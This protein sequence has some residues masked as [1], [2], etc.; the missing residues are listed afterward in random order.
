MASSF[1]RLLAF[2][3]VLLA[4]G[5]GLAGW[6]GLSTLSRAAQD[7]TEGAIRLTLDDIAR[8][9][10]AQDAL[11]IRPGQQPELARLIEAEAR[12]SGDLWQIRL[13]DRTGALL[14]ESPPQGDAPGRLQIVT[15][16]VSDDLGNPLA[17]LNALYDGTAQQKQT[18]SLS[19]SLIGPGILLWLGLTGITALV[20]RAVTGIGG[21]GRPPASLPPA[22]LRPAH[23]RLR[24]A[25]LLATLLMVSSLALS[26]LLFLRGSELLAPGQMQKADRLALSLA[27][28]VERAL[29]LGIPAAA[30]R[31][32]PEL[33]EETR[34]DNPDLAQIRLELQGLAPSTAGHRPADATE[35]SRP[36]RNPGAGGGEDPGQIVVTPD[37]AF[38][39]RNMIGIAVDL[40]IITLVITLI[41]LE[42]IGAVPGILPNGQPGAMSA[43]G[44][45]Q[46][47]T[48]AIRAPLFLFMF[49]QELSRPFLPARAIE[50]SGDTGWLS[51][52][53]AASLPLSAFMA[54]VALLQLPL[55]T[56]SALWGRGI[57]FR[58]GALTGAAG[59]FLSALA[60]GP[61]GLI[62]AQIT[63]AIGFALVFVSCQGHILDTSAGPGRVA[64]LATM[65]GAIMVAGLC[66]PAVGG[67]VASAFGAEVAFL[68]MAL[69]ALAALAIGWR[70]IPPRSSAPP[71][72]AA[73]E[74]VGRRSFTPDLTLVALLAGCALPAKIL[75]FA[76]CFYLI[77]LQMAAE[78]A[79]LLEIGRMQMIYPI[80][81]VLM[82]P[83]LSQLSRQLDRRLPFVLAGA[84]LA[85][86]ALGLP[87]FS[88]GDP[89]PFVVLAVLLAGFGLAQSLSITP[90]AA[91]VGEIARARPGSDENRAYGLY[92]LIERAGSAL[93]PV[94][95]ALILPVFG[96]AGSLGLLAG[97]SLSGALVFAL[98]FIVSRGKDQPAERTM[99]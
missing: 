77:P 87:M 13:R 42:L 37:P 38:L 36:I 15:Q 80:V 40:A 7:M 57:S 75:L 45:D 24:I 20:L 27:T 72:D 2:L 8:S 65:V 91:L 48:G 11:G 14:L 4:G 71:R 55:A 34:A 78:G 32:V 84:A 21:A 95:G 19:R 16:V 49:A 1:M 30:L 94:I 51:P 85:A 69:I 63:A 74:P 39:A 43:G 58:I 62:G 73:R 9:I 23:L 3:A 68:L 90:Q 17:E 28:K 66:G 18:A 79:S 53:L 46:A 86:L 92:R 41:G 81:T 89:V 35:V 61:L 59:F 25:L 6:M 96:F 29:E 76:T 26:A 64:G 54:V 83:G 31:G 5:L 56:R 60:S 12:D 44:R 82:I 67:M 70:T 97:L 50:L 10:T 88:G 22:T 93:G 33:L 99:I 52:G 47:A 98:V